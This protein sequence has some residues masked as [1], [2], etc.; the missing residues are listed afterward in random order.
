M[1]PKEKA[2]ELVLKFSIVGLQ[3]RNEGIVCALIAV[4]ELIKEYSTLPHFGELYLENIE[5][6]EEVKQEIE[7]L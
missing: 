4:D 5:Y 1:T 6:W 3:Q 2:T 7:L